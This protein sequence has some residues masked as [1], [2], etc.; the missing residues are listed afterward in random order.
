VEEERALLVGAGA[1]GDEGVRVDERDRGAG[2][3][4]AGAFVHD[5]AEDGLGWSARG[6]A[7]A[8]QGQGDEAWGAH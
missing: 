2:E 1:V 8:G 7:R 4:A 3:G 5:D 6:E